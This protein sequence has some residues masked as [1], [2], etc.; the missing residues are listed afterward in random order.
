MS[1]PLAPDAVSTEPAKVPNDE[2]GVTGRV[3]AVPLIVWGVLSLAFLGYL[4]FGSV[5]AR[6]WRTVSAFGVSRWEL[7]VE[8]R[9]IFTMWRI[10]GQSLRRSLTSG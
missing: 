9:S 4:A 1:E 5:D 3:P 10:Q 2:S 8:P 6:M 7:Q